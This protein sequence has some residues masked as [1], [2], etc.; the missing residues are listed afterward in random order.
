MLYLHYK[1][2]H[3]VLWTKK[4]LAK[5]NRPVVL[6]SCDYW[7]NETGSIF[8][9]LTVAQPVKETFHLARC[10]KF[11]VVFWRSH[12]ERGCA[13][14]RPYTGKSVP[15]SG[16]TQESLCWLQDIHRKVCADLR[17]YTGKSVLTSGH[18]QENLCWPQAI[19][20]KVCAGL[21]PYTG[22]FVLA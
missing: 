16:H 22:K 14:L 4:W 2:K 18:T 3:I 15:T 11:I 9:N 10:Q 8:D 19:H 7:F 12:V 13:Y 21:S 5:M 17:P 1:H 6:N 20:R